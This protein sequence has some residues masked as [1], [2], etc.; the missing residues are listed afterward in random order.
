MSK[1]QDFAETA[2]K[3]GLVHAMKVHYPAMEMNDKGTFAERQALVDAR[4]R[5]INAIA[6]LTGCGFSAAESYVDGKTHI[7]PGQA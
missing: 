1:A 2:Q 7:L 5:S 6:K 3:S 4:Q